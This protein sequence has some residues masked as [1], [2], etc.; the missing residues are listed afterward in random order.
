MMP[1][2]WE[3]YGKIYTKEWESENGIKEWIERAAGDENARFAHTT[4]ISKATATH[5]NTFEILL[6]SLAVECVHC[7]TVA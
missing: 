4:V 1:A 7:L 5:R 6:L 2:K 3:K